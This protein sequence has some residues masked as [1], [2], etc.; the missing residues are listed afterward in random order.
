MLILMK[1]LKEQIDNVDYSWFN[2]HSRS[3]E[4]TIIKIIVLIEATIVYFVLLYQVWFLQIVETKWIMVP[5]K[6]FLI[7]SIL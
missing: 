1:K 7:T 3:I 5:E 6:Q 2:L 4:I